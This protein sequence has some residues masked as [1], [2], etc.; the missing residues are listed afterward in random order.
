[1]LIWEI[2]GPKMLYRWKH[3]DGA[4]GVT[5]AVN[6]RIISGTGTYRPEIGSETIVA[7]DNLRASATIVTALAVGVKSIIPVVSDEPAFQL[8]SD[9]V[10]TAGEKNG[11]RLQGYDLGNSP[12]EIIERYTAAPFNTL[13]LRTTNLVPFLKA[14]SQAYICSSLNISA[15]AS[16]LKKNDLCI[17]A[18]GGTHGCTEDLGVALC[19][20][21]LVKG[22]DFPA[23]AAAR[24]TWESPAAKHLTDIGYGRDVEFISRVDLYNCIPYYDGTLITDY[25]KG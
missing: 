14:V 6:C 20:S 13:V 15:T 22:I 2:Y 17:C 16:F 25:R 4:S 23:E 24:F 11:R 5:R 9:V 8:K 10:V 12:G 18:V 21:A 1:M 7:I 3:C 19:L